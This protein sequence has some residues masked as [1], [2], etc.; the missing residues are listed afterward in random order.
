MLSARNIILHTAKAVQTVPFF[1]SV[2]F[3]SSL[4]ISHITKQRA[5]SWYPAEHKA[6]I[7]KPVCFQS[8]KQVSANLCFQRTFTVGFMPS[9]GRPLI[10][11]SLA[12]SCSRV[13]G[14]LFTLKPL[15]TV[16]HPSTT[17]RHG[18]AAL[19]QVSLTCDRNEEVASATSR[20]H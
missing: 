18:A 17:T 6:S 13:A 19:E 2:T 20:K 14:S 3:A 15:V 1:T 16:D 7:C 8:M 4:S 5:A 9:I 11:F 10:S 12:L